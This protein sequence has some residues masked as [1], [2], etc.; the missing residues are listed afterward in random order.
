M[1]YSKI[2]PIITILLV[3]SSACGF[4]ASEKE[5]VVNK[6]EMLEPTSDTDSEKNTNIS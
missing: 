2:I 5:P 6:S 1:H 3:I 4:Q